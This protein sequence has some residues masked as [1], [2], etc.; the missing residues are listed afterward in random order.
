MQR[1]ISSAETSGPAI[2]LTDN[3]ALFPV[4][5]CAGTVAN[6]QIL[7]RTS[8]TPDRKSA[9]QRLIKQEP[10]TPF[11]AFVAIGEESAPSSPV[12]PVAQAGAVWEPRLQPDTCGS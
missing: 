6:S 5:R 7:Q 12:L 3:D 4:T 9:I 2:I 1:L 10:I 11:C 8:A